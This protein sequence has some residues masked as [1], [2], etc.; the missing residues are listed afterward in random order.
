MGLIGRTGGFCGSNFSRPAFEAFFAKLP[1]TE[2]ALEACGGSHHWGRRLMELG[3]QVRLIPPQYIKPF[4]KRGKNDR[5]D[6]EAI[7]EAAGRPGMSTAPIKPAERQAQA[8]I[9]SV[10]DLLV[11]QRTQAINA[12]RGHAAEF[13]VIAVKGTSQVTMLMERVG[14]TDAAVPTAAQQMLGALAGEVEHFNR[15][16]AALVRRCG[17]RR[18]RTKPRAA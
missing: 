2:A 3:H 1:P 12:L 17:E 16:I 6:A 10:R 9:V 7:C 4:V 8:M 11:R 5:N 14:S 18:P 15:Q 13:G